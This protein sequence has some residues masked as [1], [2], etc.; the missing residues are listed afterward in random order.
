MTEKINA[1]LSPVTFHFSP[2]TPHCANVHLDGGYAFSSGY[3]FAGIA[4][5]SQEAE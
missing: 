2:F 5:E 1:D 3:F 4:G